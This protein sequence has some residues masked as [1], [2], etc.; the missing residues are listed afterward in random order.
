MHYYLIV[1]RISSGYD[2]VFTP[3]DGI[4]N[5]DDA[6]DDVW[7]ENENSRTTSVKFTDDVENEKPKEVSFY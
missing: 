5:D 7:E 1:G 2:H 4:I 6:E 3:S